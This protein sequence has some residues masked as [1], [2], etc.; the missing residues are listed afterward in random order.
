MNKKINILLVMVL[1]LTAYA[2]E[3]Y[4]LK[5]KNSING[6][7]LENTQYILNDYI[8]NEDETT[9]LFLKGKELKTYDKNSK[10]YYIQTMDQIAENGKMVDSQ[11]A[12][13]RMK[14]TGKKIKVGQWDTE[15][16]SAK[17]VLMGMNT[18][19]DIY[20]CKDDNIPT[21][22]VFKLQSK[23]YPQA[24]N[25]QNMLKQLKNAGGFQVKSVAR[26]KNMGV[27]ASEITRE[28]VELKK[29]EIDDEIFRE[30]QDYKLVES[31]T[32]LEENTEEK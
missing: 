21:D 26:I 27:V 12:D 1:C 14:S 22:L 16:Y 20:I 9:I 13:F 17:F 30:P 23:L 24:K 28:L 5:Q 29:V 32:N 7:M 6:Q 2:A 19:A 3:G 18:E 11:F 8:R 15:I 10:T 31:I 25:I 4:Y